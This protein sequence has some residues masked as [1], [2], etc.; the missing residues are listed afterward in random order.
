M[1]VSTMVV[2]RILETSLYLFFSVIVDYI[3]VDLASFLEILGCVSVVDVI[4]N[5]IGLYFE[6]ITQVQECKII[7]GRDD[8]KFERVGIPV[9]LEYL[10]IF[11]MCEGLGLQAQF[12]AESD[13]KIWVAKKKPRPIS[14]V[15]S[16]TI[17]MFCEALNLDVKLAHS[18]AREYLQ[19]NQLKLVK[20]LP[21]VHSISIFKMCEALGLNVKL[22]A[23]I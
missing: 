13:R 4:K 16:K 20:L 3:Q 18:P 5:F 9:V 11:K 6:S 10:K 14:K 21:V 19:E 2:L 12:A 1:I 17:L 22:N 23:E 7:V 15:N 8:D